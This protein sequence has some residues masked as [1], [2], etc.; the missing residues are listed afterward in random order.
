[1]N[2]VANCPNCGA[3][4]TSTKCEYCGTIFDRNCNAGVNAS[5]FNA[6]PDWDIV[7]AISHFGNVA[8]NFGNTIIRKDN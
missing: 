6:D 2:L 5:S 7:K 3:V 1:M 8:Y 4:I